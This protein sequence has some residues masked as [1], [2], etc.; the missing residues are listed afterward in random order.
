MRELTAR[1]RFGNVFREFSATFLDE[2][3][4][5]QNMASQGKEMKFVVNRE[6]EGAQIYGFSLVQVFCGAVVSSAFLL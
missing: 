2:F 5:S 1:S 3:Y 6:S 4:G